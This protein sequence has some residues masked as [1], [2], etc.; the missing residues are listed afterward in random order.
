[1]KETPLLFKAEM[2][3]AILEHR[4]TQTR[5]V[6]KGAWHEP[7]G[8]LQSEPEG[9]EGEWWFSCS[10]VPASFVTKCPYGSPGDRIWVKE[11]WKPHCEGPI[12]EEFPL[13]TCVKYKADGKCVKPETWTHNQGYWCESQEETTRWRPSIFMPR[14]ASR[15]TLEVVSVRVERLQDITEDD[16]IAEGILPFKLVAANGTTILWGVAREQSEHGSTARVGYEILWDSINI[17]KAASG[18]KHAAW[19]TNPWVWVVSFKLCPQT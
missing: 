6:V 14:W 13:G 10:K 5:R 17:G 18:G 1:M 8:Y 7:G 12:S 11:T 15:I 2:V 4:K 9:D 3:R 19:S 16:A